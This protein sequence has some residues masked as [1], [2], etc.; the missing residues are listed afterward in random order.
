[1]SVGGEVCVSEKGKQIFGMPPNGNPVTVAG[2]DGSGS[3]T[4]ASTSKPSTTLPIDVTTS[5][6]HSRKPV[7]GAIATD[8]VYASPGLVTQTAA[9]VGGEPSAGGEQVAGAQSSFTE[10]VPSARDAERRAA[11]IRNAG[12]RAAGGDSSSMECLQ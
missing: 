2:G 6:A 12:D 10:G 5:V 9:S 1:M 11:E 3:D 7:N 4:F 8:A